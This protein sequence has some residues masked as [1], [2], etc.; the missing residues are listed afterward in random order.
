MQGRQSQGYTSNARRGIGTGTT[1]VIRTVGDLNANPLKVIKCYN[2]R[3]EADGLEG[4]DSDCKDLQLNATS[5]LMTEKVEA[6]DSD[7]FGRHLKEK[8]VTCARFRKKL[9]KN[10]TLQACDFHSGAFTKSAQKVKFLI[11]SA[12]SYQQEEPFGRFGGL[13]VSGNPSEAGGGFRKRSLEE[14]EEEEEEDDLEYFKTFPHR[15]E[16]EYHEYLLK[17]LALLGLELKLYYYWIMNEGLESRKKPSNPKDVSS[18]IY[19]NLGEMILEKPFVKQ[20]K[21]T[22]DKEEGTVMFE[23][24][25]E[26]ITFKIPHKMERFKDIEDLNTDNIPPFF[27]ARHEYKRDEG[28]I[29]TI[30][31]LYGRS[32][33]AK[34]SR[35]ECDSESS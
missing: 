7:S 11:K 27:I 17:I 33:Q 5:I 22:Y 21:L 12:T 29:K 26:R 8:H 13:M 24:N 28:V 10:T 25:D 4:F 20:S 6:Y 35:K 30:K 18:V 31:F 23:K 3:G 2:C 16:L 32:G 15:E 9:D 14:F 19:H 1:T 34:E